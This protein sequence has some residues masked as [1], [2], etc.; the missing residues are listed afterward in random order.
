MTQG[1]SQQGRQVDR[2]IPLIMF[3]GDR[4][5]TVA[6]VNA[7]HLLDQWLQAANDRSGTTHRSARDV[8]V[9]RGQVAG[10]HAYT[11]SIYHDVSGRVAVEQWTIHKAGHAWS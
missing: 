6:T 8:K 4:D 3:H 1:A 11:R 5:T 2:V 10:G 7:D 9:E